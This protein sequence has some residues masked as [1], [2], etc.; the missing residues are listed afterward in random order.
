MGKRIV[1]VME[2]LRERKG[3]GSSIMGRPCGL[4]LETPWDSGKFA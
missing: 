1:N 4:V 3:V 2:C